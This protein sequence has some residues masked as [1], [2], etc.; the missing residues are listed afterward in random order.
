MHTGGALQTPS[1]G[2]LWEKIGSGTGH[3][4]LWPAT[5]GPGIVAGPPEPGPGPDLPA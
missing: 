4:I 5:A 1:E 2:G 3:W